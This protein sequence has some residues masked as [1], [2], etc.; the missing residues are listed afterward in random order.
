MGSAQCKLHSRARAFVVNDIRVPSA[1]AWLLSD[2]P[3]AR[4]CG[5][6]NAELDPGQC[7]VDRLAVH[8]AKAERW[9]ARYHQPHRPHDAASLLIELRRAVSRS[10]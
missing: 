6:C 10:R 7:D 8:W 4:Q 2:D 5:G 9:E 1:R 3:E